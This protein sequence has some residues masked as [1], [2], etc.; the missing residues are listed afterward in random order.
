MTYS[1]VSPDQVQVVT[2]T[3]ERLFILFN[4]LV[5]PG[6]GVVVPFPAFQTLYQV[7]KDIGANIR[8]VRPQWEDRFQLRPDAV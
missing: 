5:N 2:D 8:L 4:L 6:D 1:N 3:S 7:L